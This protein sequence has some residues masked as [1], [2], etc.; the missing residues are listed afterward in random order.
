MQ[1]EG[2]ILQSPLSAAGRHDHGIKTRRGL[3]VQGLGFRVDD[4]LLGGSCDVVS[5]AICTL[6]GVIRKFK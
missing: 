2:D 3:R 5:M 1:E 4:Y 6:S